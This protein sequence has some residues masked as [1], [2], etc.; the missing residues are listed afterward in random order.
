M[1]VRSSNGLSPSKEDTDAKPWLFFF[2]APNLI[3]LFSYEVL[4][5]EVVF[6]V[7][8]N[9]HKYVRLTDSPQF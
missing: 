9:P 6:V 2:Y 7:G 1:W 5:P 4:D 8:P 3:K